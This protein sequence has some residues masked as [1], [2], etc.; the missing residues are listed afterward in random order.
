MFDSLSKQNYDFRKINVENISKLI[1]F[2][3]KRKMT[4]I[5]SGES[6]KLIEGTDYYSALSFGKTYTVKSKDINSGRLTVTI[7]NDLGFARSYPYRIFETVS[8]LRN[9]ALDELLNDL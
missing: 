2:E 3:I 1:Q 4:E 7:E 9:S 5:E 6:V 8:N